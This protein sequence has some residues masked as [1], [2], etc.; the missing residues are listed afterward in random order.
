LLPKLNQD[1]F[2]QVAN[3]DNDEENQLYKTRIADLDDDYIYMEQPIHTMKGGFMTL[4]QG[5]SLSIYFL[6]TGGTKNYFYSEVVGF[7][8]DNI[9]LVTITKP[10]QSAI[11]QVQRRNHLRVAA[12]LEIAIRISDN[13]QFLA[14]T[15]DLSGGG[16]AFE[17]ESHYAIQPNTQFDGWLLLPYKNGS[18]EHASFKGEIVRIKELEG[19]LKIGMVTFTNISDVDRQRVIRYCFEKQLEYRKK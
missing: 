9:R 12:E 1:L 7:Q 19:G 14:V 11:S 3:V 8:E 2:I 18:I 13:L 6:S 5:D 10:E 15:K 17:C 16:T 4:F